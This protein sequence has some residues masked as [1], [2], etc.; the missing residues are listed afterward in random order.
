[1]EPQHLLVVRMVFSSPVPLQHTSL[2]DSVLTFVYTRTT[3]PELTELFRI[4][5]S[6]I[7]GLHY[8]VLFHCIQLYVYVSSSCSKPLLYDE[9]NSVSRHS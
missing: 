2:L 1:M 9:F 8:S 6:G 5:Y 3:D 4:I 7:E